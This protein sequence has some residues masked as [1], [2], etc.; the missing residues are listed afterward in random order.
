MK[1]PESRR[2]KILSKWHNFVLKAEL[3]LVH[4]LIQE[5]SRTLEVEGLG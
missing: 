5:Q 2:S 3:G 4:W 1:L